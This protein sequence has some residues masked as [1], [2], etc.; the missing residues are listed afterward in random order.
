MRTAALAVCLSVLTCRTPAADLPPRQ[1]EAPAG[2]ALAA[3]LTSLALEDREALL[4][5]QFLSG[6]VPAWWRR[7]V[8]VTLRRETAG[9]PHVAVCEVAPD[10]VCVGSDDDFLR[11]PLSPPAAWR[12]ATALDCILPTTGLS[13]AIHAAATVRLDP[14]PLPP[15]PEMTE[16][17]AFLTHHRLVEAQWAAAGA[18]R[19]ALVAGHKKDVVL[20]G[21]LAPHSGRV[22]I[23]GWHRPDG[24]P[25][26]PLYTGHTQRWVDYSHGVRLVRRRVLV[27]STATRIEE[28][29]TDPERC[30]LLGETSPL[31]RTA[32]GTERTDILRPIPGVRAVVQSPFRLTPGAPVTLVIYGTPNGSSAAQTLGVP[33]AEAPEPRWALQR[34]A[35]QA[36]WLRTHGD[37]PNLVLAAVECDGLAWPAWR[38]RHDPEDRRL[39][40][41]V[42]ALRGRFRGRDVRVMLAGHSGGGSFTFGWMNALAELPPWLSGLAFLDS[43]YAW[44]SERHAAKLTAWLA[45]GPDRRLFVAAYHDSIATLDGRPFVSESGG[46]WG[47]TAAMLDALRPHFPLTETEEGP[48]L[49]ARGLDGRLEIL[50]HRNPERKILHTLLVERNGL[51]HA[52]LGGTPLSGGAYQF[53]GPPVEAPAGGT[54]S[55]K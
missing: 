43:N 15:G 41:V 55:A 42:D 1:P 52:L 26:Q 13:D 9:T 5:D 44:D 8:P 34:I 53:F 17:A 50:R 10:V 28:I 37:L 12:L 46:T 51:V 7:F 32:E 31:R 25:V 39:P 3:R 18:E 2:S 47:R 38:R 23:H 19:G 4:T 33:A 36:R 54:G 24:S 48:F 45:S 29:L 27:D 22:A 11:I 40:A 16:P 6:N 14:Q 30:V 35:A 21:T 49:A 20:T